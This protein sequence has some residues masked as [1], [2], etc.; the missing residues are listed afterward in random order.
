MTTVYDYQTIDES[1]ASSYNTNVANVVSPT[2]LGR[3]NLIL[4]Y[5]SKL[6]STVSNGTLKSTFSYPDGSYLLTTSGGAIKLSG[7]SLS[8]DVLNAT[9]MTVTSTDGSSKVVV[10]GSINFNSSTNVW[11]GKYTSLYYGG[12]LT[13]AYPYSYKLDGVINESNGVVSG[14]ANSIQYLYSNSVTGINEVT[15]YGLGSAYVGWDYANASFLLS[16]SSQVT[17]VKYQATNTKG[18]V[19]ASVD[20]FNASAVAADTPNIYWLIMSGNDVVYTS[21]NADGLS[22]SGYSGNDLLV[23]DAGDNYFNNRVEV[24]KYIYSGL[25][26]DTIKGGDGNDVVYYGS[27]KSFSSFAISN[28]DPANNGI[29][30]T[31]LSTTDNVGVDKFENIEIFQFSDV[32][33]EFSQLKKFI[34]WVEATGGVM[35]YG[36]SAAEAMVGTTKDDAFNGLGG[37]DTLLGA[38]GNDIIYGG[39]GNDSL[40]GGDGYDVCGYSGL[41]GNY[42]LSVNNGYLLVQDKL[43]VEGTDTTKNFEKLQFSDKSVV[44]ES[45]SHGSYTSL[46]TE[47]YQFFITAFNAAPGVSYMDQLAEAYNYG[48][49]VKQIVNVFTTKSQFTSVYPTTLSNQELATQLVTNIVKSSATDTVKAQAVTDI[50]AALDYG[51]TVGDVIFNVFGNLAKKSLTDASW[52][53]TAKQFNNQITVAKYYTDTLSQSTTDFETLKDVIQ[54]VTATTDVSS[55]SVVASLIGVALLNGGVV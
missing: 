6:I 8:G 27:N 43:G 33:L 37:N 23:G 36:V 47:L 14:A 13:S 9:Q 55:D 48:L 22:A 39:S 32:N 18:V 4:Q 20:Y 53:N 12:N 45:K 41:A 30:F 49:S 42:K 38:A 54:S 44:I 7:I 26:N 10:N 16:S 17:S 52:G 31:D 1:I 50:K 34:L 35:K 28:F 19:T 24:S 2:A 5:A 15:D 40:E 51:L 11:S 25:G 46:P 29:V 3:W 21:G